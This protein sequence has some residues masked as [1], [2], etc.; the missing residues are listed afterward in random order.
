MKAVLVGGIDTDKLY[1]VL[2]AKGTDN[3]GLIVFSDGK[4]IEIRFLSWVSK[5]PRVRKIR[6]TKFHRFLWDS[7]VNP[8]K[9]K[10][11]DTF[12]QKNLEMD[13]LILEGL[14]IRTDLST[15]KQIVKKKDARITA[16]LSN[17]VNP[18]VILS[19]STVSDDNDKHRAWVAMSIFK[20]KKEEI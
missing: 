7:P 10:W 13:K 11:F 20:Q 5:N 2:D 3:D 6:N 14:I 12:V 8:T 19:K 4:I 17:K 16:F 18:T 9:G 1:Y 15:E